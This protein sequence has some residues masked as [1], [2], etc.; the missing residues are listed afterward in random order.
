MRPIR[1]PCL[2]ALFVASVAA[3]PLHAQDRASWSTLI[4]S[5]Y[6]DNASYSFL[7]RICDEAGG[8]MVGSAD[9]ERAL[10]ILTTE[11]A[12]HDCTVRLE[13]FRFPGFVRG[14]DVVEILEPLSRKLR[15][16][17]L[18][19]VDASPRIEATLVYA[20]EGREDSY[21]G[22]DVH[23]KI[24]LVTQE[25]V[26][27]QPEFLR[28]EAIAI[29]SA[30]KAKAILFIKDTPGGTT[31]AGMANFQG[32]P[33]PIPA[34]SLTFEEGKWL[35]RLCDAGKSVRIGI[36]TRSAMRELETANAVV[37]LPGAS[38]KKLVIGAHFDA[39]DVGQGAVDNGIGTA[40]L[41][42]V[43]RLLKRYSPH[44]A[45]TVECVWFNGEEIG[46]DGSKK[47]MELHDKD[48]IVAMINMDMTG[49]PTSFSAG[50]TDA[51]LPFLEK[52]AKDL[53]GFSI[54]PAIGNTA[55]TNSD[56]Q[57]FMLHGI[58]TIAVW[59]KLDPEMV[60]NY[61]DLGDSFDKV[62]KR[63]LSDAA[64]VVSVLARELAN[65]TTLSLR[66]RSAAETV[67]FLKKQGLEDRLRR[68]KEWIF[69]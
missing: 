58:P 17:A 39:W 62:S 59:G 63:Y 16:V 68:Q 19:N 27:G 26:A 18:G 3:L 51:L 57:P 54:S 6:L 11:M 42:D 55:G 60:K 1:I 25:H 64:A 21:G 48:S 33:C 44:N 49:S 28:S 66:R 7:Q 34:F 47:Y 52:L 4:A 8:R 2:L 24:V 9:N 37:T 20:K 14:D 41:F 61:H 53:N 43:A 29:A 15:A 31:L 65:T 23:G 40:I 5:A 10:A 46:L 22:L 56:H 12:K 67:E 32:T 36:T 69:E 45:L 30:K 13:R 50:G 35:Q 38:T